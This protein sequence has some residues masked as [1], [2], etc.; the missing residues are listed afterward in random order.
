MGYNFSDITETGS[1]LHTW[2]LF[3]ILLKFSCRIRLILIYMGT[4]QKSKLQI[5]IYQDHTYI[6]GGLQLVKEINLV[7]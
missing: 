4:T 5:A 7:R 1:S 2:G 6:Q 3:K